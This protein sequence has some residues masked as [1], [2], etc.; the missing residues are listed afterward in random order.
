MRDLQPFPKFDH[1]LDGKCGSTTRKIT[2]KWVVP[3]YQLATP[4]NLNFKNLAIHPN[5]S[6]HPKMNFTLA[7]LVCPKLHLFCTYLP[8]LLFLTLYL[9]STHFFFFILHLITILN[10][11]TT[12]NCE[13]Q[14]ERKGARRIQNL[15]CF[16]C[17]FWQIMVAGER[18][19]RTSL[20]VI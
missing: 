2:K 16:S 13:L 7:I 5:Y 15:R 12:P 1:Y 8:F 11:V 14:F 18:E 19:G 9:T 20:K 17:S 3:T 4:F 10:I 6:L